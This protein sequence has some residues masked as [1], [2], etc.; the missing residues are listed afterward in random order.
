MGVQSTIEIFQK[1]VHNARQKM[2]QSLAGSEKLGDVVNLHLTLDLSRRLLGN[3]PNEVIEI[4]KRDVE[5]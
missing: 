3:L 2:E 1:A 4:V 5:R